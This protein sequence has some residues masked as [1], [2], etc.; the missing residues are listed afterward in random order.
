M[1]RPAG[2]GFDL[3]YGIVG[4]VRQAYINDHIPSA[5]RATVLS[6]DSFF[7]DIGA[8][9]GQLGLGYAAQVASKALPYTIG[10]IAYFVAVPLYARAGRASDKEAGRE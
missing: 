7:S 10:G 6:F 9:G 1:P 2:G 5:Q 8:V 4:P 3:L